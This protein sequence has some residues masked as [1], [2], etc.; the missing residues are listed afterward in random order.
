MQH[1]GTCLQFLRVLCLCKN[2]IEHGEIFNAICQFFAMF[3]DLGGKFVKDA[4]FFV[5]FL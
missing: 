2:K 4:P 1:W 3:T 5:V